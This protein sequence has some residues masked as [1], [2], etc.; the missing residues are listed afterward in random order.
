MNSET[1]R[2]SIVEQTDKIA[3]TLKLD[4]VEIVIRNNYKGGVEIDVY[5]L[6]QKDK[7]VTIR[8]GIELSVSESEGDEYF[9]ISYLKGRVRQG[10][11]SVYVDSHGFRAIGS[12]H[13]ERT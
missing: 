2:G 10:L 11:A 9:S 8:N 5:G 13:D 4:G 12:L 3:A 6:N 1:E 7:D